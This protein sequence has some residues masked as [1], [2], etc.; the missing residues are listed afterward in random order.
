MNLASLNIQVFTSNLPNL[1]EKMQITFWPLMA[2][3]G[4]G[5]TKLVISHYPVAQ[6]Q[7]FFLM[8]RL[9]IVLSFERYYLSVPQTY[10][11]LAAKLSKNLKILISRGK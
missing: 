11:H 8:E 10:C 6:L 9:K 3:E 7:Q 2:V 1:D 4:L 5:A